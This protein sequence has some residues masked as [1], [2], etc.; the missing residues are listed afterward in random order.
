MLLALTQKKITQYYMKYISV[1]YISHNIFF[2]HL[3]LVDVDVP[4]V[5]VEEQSRGVDVNWGLPP[6][7]A[8]Q[9]PVRVDEAPERGPWGRNSSVRGMGRCL[10]K[11]KF[12][13][14]YN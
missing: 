11:D 13:T 8:A 14:L 7:E 5:G 4:E 1:I 6:A 12:A 2:T 3:V 9:A 10:A